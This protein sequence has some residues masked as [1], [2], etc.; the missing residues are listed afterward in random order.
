MCSFLLFGLSQIRRSFIN[1]IAD[2][3]RIGFRL[4][5]IK[6]SLYISSLHPKLR[7]LLPKDANF[8]CDSFLGK[9]RMNV[10]NIYGIESSVFL[11]TYEPDVIRTIYEYVQSGMIVFDVGA[12]V[13]PISFAL[14]ERVGQGG[15]VFSF[16]PGPVVFDRFLR[17]IEMNPGL[18]R[19][20]SAHNMGLAD[21][22]GYLLYHEL[23]HARG[24]AV[25]YGSDG[26]WEAFESH[27]VKVTTIDEFVK[28]NS[29]THVDFIKIDV[30]GMEYEVLLGAIDTLKSWRPVICYETLSQVKSMTGAVNFRRIQSFLMEIGYDLFCVEG[31]RQQK[32][33]SEEIF[34]LNTLAICDK[35]QVPPILN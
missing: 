3:I 10:K 29:L 14:A 16:E 23:A 30:E 24:N 27:Q 6:A 28:A 31:D 7:L 11:G 20:I 34:T 19:V 33:A 17:N 15:K 12:N 26:T 4:L 1:R 18:D 2:I 35:A 5:P 32:K 8:V 21:K 25:L 9:Y 13:G 22:Q